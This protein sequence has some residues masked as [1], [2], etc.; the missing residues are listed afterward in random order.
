MSDNGSQPTSMAFMPACAS[1]GIHQAFTRDHHPKGNAN[2]ERAMRPLREEC[3]W[4]QEWTCPF[5]RIRALG[6][7][8]DYDRAH[9]L[10]SA[11]GYKMPRQHE[12]EYHSSHSSP[13]VAA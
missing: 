9:D 12:Q 8:I 2:T 10:H 3:L 1:V 6:G 7:W 11:L 4:W 13:F 5:E